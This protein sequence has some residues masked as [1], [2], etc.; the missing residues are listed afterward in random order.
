MNLK[1]LHE[2]TPFTSHTNVLFEL[3]YE[4]LTYLFLIHF[5]LDAMVQISKNAV[6]VN[7]DQ[8]PK[9]ISSYNLNLEISARL[10]WCPKKL[11]TFDW[12]QNK[13]FLFNYQGFFW[14]Q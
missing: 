6:S 5:S 4:L 11:E 9:F 12:L 8:F 14:F 7:M 13:R 3:L 2:L 1:V 10:A